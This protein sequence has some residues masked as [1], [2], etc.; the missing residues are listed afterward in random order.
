MKTAK[1]GETPA[2][3]G[4]RKVTV[5]GD[6]IALDPVTQIV[7]L[8]GPAAHSGLESAGSRSSST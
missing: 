2:A 3:Q 7:T 5:V 4:S 6:V 8:K 1:P